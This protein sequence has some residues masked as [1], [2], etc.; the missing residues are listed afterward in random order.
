MLRAKYLYATVRIR[1]DK[2]ANFL[3]YYHSQS[4]DDPFKHALNKIIQQHIEITKITD[5]TFKSPVTSEGFYFKMGPETKCT[6]I[7]TK[8]C[9]INDIYEYDA[10]CKFKVQPYDF[11]KNGNRIVGITIKLLEANAKLDKN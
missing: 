7:T 2:F 9:I 10:S 6:R 8:P 1:N 4:N 5:E 11:N 3:E